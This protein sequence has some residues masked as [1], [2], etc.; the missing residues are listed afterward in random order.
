MQAVQLDGSLWTERLDF[1]LALRDGLGVVPAHGTGFDAF[2]DTVFYNPDMLTIRP[3][4]AITVRNASTLSRMDIAQM[5]EG[6]ALSGS[7]GER[8]MVTMP[9]LPSSR[10]HWRG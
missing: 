1:W 3:S 2:E 8:I 6:S 7:G 4:F 10:C 9:R 5:T